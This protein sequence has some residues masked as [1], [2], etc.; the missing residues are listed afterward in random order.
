MDLST[1]Q[2]VVGLLVSTVLPILVGLVTTR[3]TSAGAKSVLLLV[4]TAVNGFCVEWAASGD[5][6][7]VW[8]GVLF[9]VVSLV[10]AVAVHF[11]VWRP[12][13]AS[14]LAQDSLIT[15]GPRR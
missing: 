5:G 1:P 3:V 8:A 2:A 11:G 4:L 13:G 14:R 12:I 10:T 9:W 15:S 7:D 6:Y